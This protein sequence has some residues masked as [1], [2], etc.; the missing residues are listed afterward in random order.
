MPQYTSKVIS[1]ENA[2]ELKVWVPPNMNHGESPVSPEEVNRGF[3][4]AEDI[5]EIQEQARQESYNE[6]FSQ[7]R[8]EGLD[9]GFK[10]GVE[11]GI[12]QGTQQGIELGMQQIQETANQWQQLISC[13]AAPLASL[14]RQVEQELVAL[15]MAV[16]KHLVRRELKI[17][18]S[19]VIAVVREAVSVLPVSARDICVLLHPEDKK[20][21][22]ESLS[23]DF[24]GEESDRRWRII[25][26]PMLTRGG[27]KIETATSF[28][29]ASV[30][31]RLAAII[32]QVLGGDRQSDN[33]SSSNAGVQQPEETVQ[34][35]PDNIT[36]CQSHSSESAHAIEQNELTD[37]QL[38]SA[39][40][41]SEVN[42]S[43]S[44]E[45]HKLHGES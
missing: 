37:G 7:G 42:S 13:L 10:E 18:P 8:Q 22:Q 20:L 3:P 36:E 14:D 6:G 25:E 23:V 41:V 31:A 38:A 40:L 19:Q 30:E 9:S 39:D 4:T 45:Q 26:E 35:L 16:A 21:I 34:V 12:A 44:D 43:I 1:K 28:I 24:D 2:E 32:A 33:A 11:Q 27:C 5:E 17:D 15:A 29:D